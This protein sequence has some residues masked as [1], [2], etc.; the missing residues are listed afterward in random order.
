MGALAFENITEPAV[1]YASMELQCFSLSSPTTELGGVAR[2]LYAQVLRTL[3]EGK[4][5]VR[6]FLLSEDVR[7]AASFPHQT[8]PSDDPDAMQV[9][10]FVREL[11]SIPPGMDAAFHGTRSMFA[12]HQLLE[13]LRANPRACRVLHVP[14]WRGHGAHVALA[15]RAGLP[16][17]RNLHLNVQAHGPGFLLSM[18]SRE[19]DKSFPDA[20]RDAMERISIAHATSVTFPNTGVM[21]EVQALADVATSQRRMVVIPNIVEDIPHANHLRNVQTGR[22]R[23]II[24]HEQ[25][26]PRGAGLGLAL[27]AGAVRR[28]AAAQPALFAAAHN[29]SIVLLLA[30]DGGGISA[31]TASSTAAEIQS[32]VG[33]SAVTVVSLPSTTPRQKFLMDHAHDAV[34]VL[35]AVS[36]F[37]AFALVEV[38]QT[39]VPLLASNIAAHTALL[40]AAR[41]DELL[42]GLEAD[43]LS[44]RLQAALEKDFSTW[45]SLADHVPRRVAA[46]LWSDFHDNV[47]ASRPIPQVSADALEPVTVVVTMCARTQYLHLALHSIAAQTYPLERIHV[48]VAAA[49]PARTRCD[50]VMKSAR[51]VDASRALSSQL[52]CFDSPTPRTSLGQI[53]NLAVARVKT[54]LVVFLDDDDEFP[55]NLIADYARAAHLNPDHHVFTSFADIFHENGNEP[56][57]DR[58]VEHRTQERYVTL[59]SSPEVDLF[60]NL[61]GSSSMMVRKSSW[62]WSATGGFSDTKG[63]GCEDWEILTKAALVDAVLLVPVRGLWYRKVSVNGKL[64]GMLAEQAAPDAHAACRHRNTFGSLNFARSVPDRVRILR[65]VSA[66]DFARSKFDG[67]G[68]QGLV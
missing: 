55:S 57:P 58:I 38:M 61:V 15:V 40:P 24:F 3:R 39:G 66:M 56:I 8:C 48:L 20:V 51:V 7:G 45:R 21:R 54:D 63:V 33:D 64:T 4:H 16:E 65:L 5:R 18:Q 14:D 41:H 22:R 10:P 49:C 32:Q 50:D 29:V 34:V 59:G 60:A 2:A 25:L 44:D 6:V 23:T 19:K 12:S 43:E 52:A 26:Q 9:A 67:G 68:D 11:P 53:R 13:W 37:H 36:D 1:C 17:F 30:T 42:F 35:P 27:F 28:A 62:F 46:A 47:F 31:E